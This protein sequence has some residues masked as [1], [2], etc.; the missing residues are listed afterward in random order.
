MGA[1]ASD[2]RADEEVDD[3]QDKIPRSPLSRRIE[4]EASL[5]QDVP[6]VIAALVAEQEF[7]DDVL[8]P[9]TRSPAGDD[10][11]PYDDDEPA[12]SDKADENHAKQAS[13]SQPG[14]F[15]GSKNISS[16]GDSL[17]HQVTT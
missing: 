12:E 16:S 15:V 2:A 10:D 3:V 9:A 7:V 6:P 11:E 8:Q 4:G 5:L 1:S 17:P 13:S 14:R